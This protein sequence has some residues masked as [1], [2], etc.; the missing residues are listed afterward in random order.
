METRDQVVMRKTMNDLAE[1]TVLVAG[2]GS[3]I[4]LGIARALA[5]EGCRVVISGR[6]PQKLEVA[7][8]CPGQSPLWHYPCDVASRDDVHR[9]IDWMIR[10]LGRI[11]ILVYSAG[12]NVTR[13]RMDE[14]D[15]GDWDRILAVNCTGLFNVLRA[16]LPDMRRRRDGLIIHISSI[17]GRRASTL[18]GPAYCAAKF[19]ATALAAAVGLE[20]RANGIRIINI[21]PGEAD[22]PL[23]G[24]RPEPVPDERRQRM[25][26]P[27]DIAACVVT[28][29]KLPPHVMVPELVI[30][31]LY[32]SD[33]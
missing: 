10:E 8:R 31:P 2:G 12:I 4:G 27:E 16:V 5:G 11:E 26:H 30:T 33:A 21:Y 22:T 1:K 15:P 19:G 6:N 18:A 23:L 28:I 7:A 9:L 20:E 29:A 25:L 17:A 32:Q 14:L 13:R 3:G 24:Q